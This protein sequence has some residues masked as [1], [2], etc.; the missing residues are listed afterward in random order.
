MGDENDLHRVYVMVGYSILN[1]YLVCNSDFVKH[2]KTNHKVSVMI[3]SL[4]GLT[5]LTEKENKTANQQ[6]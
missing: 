3:I 2:E 4:T 5:N 6:L 1:L